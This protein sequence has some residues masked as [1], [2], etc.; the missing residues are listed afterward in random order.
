MKTNLEEKLTVFPDE[1]Q[2]IEEGQ[3]RCIRDLT[4]EPA[5]N[6]IQRAIQCTNN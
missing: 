1:K 5:T 2:H 6:K 4:D 3:E